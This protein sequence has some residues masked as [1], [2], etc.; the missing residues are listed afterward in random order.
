MSRACSGSRRRRHL[1]VPIDLPMKGVTA[2]R[3]S[4]AGCVYYFPDP[5]NYP[6]T[7]GVCGKFRCEAAD[8]VVSHN[9]ACGPDRSAY[10]G[11]W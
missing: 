11:S 4:C 10:R 6:R 2:T 8:A 7:T 5:P 3:T 9:K 1:R